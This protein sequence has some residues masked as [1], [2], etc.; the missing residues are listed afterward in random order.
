MPHILPGNTFQVEV[1]DERYEVRALTLKRQEDLAALVQKLADMEEGKT[2]GLGG[3]AL[4]REGLEMCVGKDNAA[5]LAESI[6]AEIAIQI[7]SKTLSKAAVD[8]EEKKRSES[9]P[10]SE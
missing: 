10:S 2:N 3:F 7:A 6:D 4:A 8:D 5:K 1:Q 9:E